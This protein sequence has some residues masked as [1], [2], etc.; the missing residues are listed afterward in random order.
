MNDLEREQTV[1]PESRSTFGTQTVGGLDRSQTCIS[2]WFVII[3]Y[4]TKTESNEVLIEYESTKPTT[5]LD[6]FV[7]LIEKRRQT[8]ETC[9][10]LPNSKN[11]RVPVP[12]NK[13]YFDWILHLLTSILTFC[14]L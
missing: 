10:F 4:D 3:N 6:L 9:E 13:Q 11:S 2:K 5:A 14:K 12:N 1:L 8:C 7:V